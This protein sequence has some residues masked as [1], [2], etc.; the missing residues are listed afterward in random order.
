MTDT[1]APV[2]GFDE[3]FSSM[4]VLGHE[5]SSK[6]MALSGETV[7]MRGYL[8]PAGHDQNGFL[9]L[10][11]APVAPC[12][13][14]ESGHDWPSDAVFV[15][16]AP[17]QDEAFAPGRIVEVRGILEHGLVRLEEVN[18][19]VRMRDARWGSS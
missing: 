4:S 3:L 15:F 6:V 17:G 7:A 11:R 12:S 10:T 5:F 19:L 2:L 1:E 8:A 9:V 18:T 16:P 13:D 14:C